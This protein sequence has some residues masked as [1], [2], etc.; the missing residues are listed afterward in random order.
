MST[1]KVWVLTRYTF[2]I[3]NFSSTRKENSYQIL[4]H[5]IFKIIMRNILI[6]SLEYNA[7]CIESLIKIQYHAI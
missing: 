7:K 4:E 6:N 2:F 1:K 3:F 5:E